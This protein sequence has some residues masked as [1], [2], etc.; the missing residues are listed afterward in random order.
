MISSLPSIAS[1]LK[2]YRIVPKKRLGQHFLAAPPTL[3]KIVRSLNPTLHDSVLEIG[4]GLGLMT[5]MLAAQCKNVIAV[6]Y[7]KTLLA[8]AKEEF[9]H[10]DNIS[11]IHADI[12]DLSF[13]NFLPQHAKIIG[14]IPYE[15]TSPILFKLLDAAN[16]VS[17][18]VL[19]IQKE[20]AKRIV[21]SPKTKDYGILAVCLQQGAKC[22]RLFDVSAK[23]FIP[24]PSVTS[25]VVRLDFSPINPRNTSWFRTVVRTAFNK[26][27]KTLRNALL[28]SALKFDEEGIDGAFRKA[29]IDGGRRP[30]TLSVQEF[31]R[32][33]K[34][35]R[36]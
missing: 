10:I 19:L 31:E 3:A 20:V 13:E 16:L 4:S 29:D 23:S 18:A 12:L 35:L 15:I 6:E 32:L 22:Q 33:A 34:A 17:S 36:E 1:L 11:W 21:A 9:G 2:K 30:E 7:D 14:N 5:A 8:V 27:R 25:S 24:A 26:R 28:T